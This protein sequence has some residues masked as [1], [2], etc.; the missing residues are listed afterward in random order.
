[1]ISFSDFNVPKLV[2]AVNDVIC[3]DTVITYKI[4]ASLPSFSLKAS[5]SCLC[6]GAM[7]K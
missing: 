5:H 3:R 2:K 1:M 4:D 7:G 6:L